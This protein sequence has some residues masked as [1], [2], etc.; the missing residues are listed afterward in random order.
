M[1]QQIADLKVSIDKLAA[2]VTTLEGKVLSQDD[3]NTL[4]GLKATVD[5]LDAKIAPT[6]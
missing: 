2:D 6:P 1:V 3:I 5:A 4:S